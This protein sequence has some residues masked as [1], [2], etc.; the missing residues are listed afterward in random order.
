M[1]CGRDVGKED[2]HLAVFDAPGASAILGSDPS[3]VAATF[4]KAAFIEH[5][6]GEGRLAGWLLL[7]GQRRA[8]AGSD[9]GAQ[10]VAHRV[11][12]P[13]GCREQALHAVGTGLPGVFSDLPAIFARD[14]TSDG[15][16]VAQGMMMGFWAREVGTQP[17][18]Q[19]AQVFV[20]SA[21]LTERWP[22]LRGVVC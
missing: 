3:R 14:G 6:D 20:P 9:Q 21:D 4:G 19:L 16:Q 15:L 22:D 11:L 7:R 10:F 18:M 2:A 13:D 12:V 17:R 1:A 8:Q 5:Q